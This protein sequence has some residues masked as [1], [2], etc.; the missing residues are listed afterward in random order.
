MFA[1]RARARSGKS[2]DYLASYQLRNPRLPENTAPKSI[3]EE[4]GF[5]LRLMDVAGRHAVIGLRSPLGS[6][7]LGN[8]LK[9]GH[10]LSLQNRPT[11]VIQNK[12]SYSSLQSVLQ[13]FL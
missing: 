4:V 2:Q 7:G 13:T 6:S 11:E 1:K 3:N 12:S 10:T 8:H 5:L 9:P